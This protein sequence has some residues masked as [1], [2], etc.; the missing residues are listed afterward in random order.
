MYFKIEEK[1]QNILC[2]YKIELMINFL[3]K[4]NFK[5]IKPPLKPKQKSQSVS[6][7]FQI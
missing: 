7:S 6:A 4:K 1:K 5:N 2:L 3:S